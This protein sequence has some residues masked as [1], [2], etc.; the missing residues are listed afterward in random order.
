M[1]VPKTHAFPLKITSSDGES[2]EISDAH[3][4]YVFEI[5]PRCDEISK[6]DRRLANWIVKVLNKA[7]NDS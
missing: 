6:G 3:G 2:I 1:K 7:A 4:F 5:Y